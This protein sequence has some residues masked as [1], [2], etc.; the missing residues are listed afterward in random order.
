MTSVN[1]PKATGSTP[2]PSPPLTL[3][4]DS[5]FVGKDFRSESFSQPRWWDSGSCYTALLKSDARR[6]EPAIGAPN[7]GGVNTKGGK[8][9]EDKHSSFPT[10]DLV[11]HDVSTGTS[12]TYVSS[13]LLIPPGHDQ[14]L[15]V[16]DYA[17]S[18]DKSRLL[19]FTNS[20]KVWRKKTRGDYWVLV[21]SY[22]V[23]SG[24][25]LDVF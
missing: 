1:H 22:L 23:C 12:E 14:P 17:L 6:R 2:S 21:S 3:S 8:D 24:T 13:D 10:R 11:W 18:P 5:I 15:H 20:Q 16:D 25:M 7:G 4:I 9:K 19:I